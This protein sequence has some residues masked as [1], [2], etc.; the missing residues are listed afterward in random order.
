M[1]RWD[2]EL[3]VH[4]EDN[5]VECVVST[6]KEECMLFAGEVLVNSSQCR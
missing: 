3:C 5:F 2:V 1:R 6:S 4:W